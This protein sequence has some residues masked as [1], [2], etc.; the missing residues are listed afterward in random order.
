MGNSYANK[1]GIFNFP[2][3]KKLKCRELKLLVQ[4]VRGGTFRLCLRYYVSKGLLLFNRRK[5]FTSHGDT[6]AF[7]LNYESVDI[8][9]QVGSFQN[10]FFH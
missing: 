6:I 1:R 8:G 2:Q 10:R 4:I 5:N 3:R 7:Q 9:Q